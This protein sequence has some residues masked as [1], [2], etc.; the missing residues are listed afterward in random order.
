MADIGYYGPTNYN[1]SL[2]Y[3][4]ERQITKANNFEADSWINGQALY[5]SIYKV[6]CT[7]TK[8]YEF[9]YDYNKSLLWS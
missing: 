7:E 2:W 4:G 3:A 1:P 9:K 5:G 8:L 6:W